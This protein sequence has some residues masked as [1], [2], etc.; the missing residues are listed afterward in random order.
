MCSFLHVAWFSPDRIEKD[1]LWEAIS[2]ASKYASGNLL[3]IGCGKKPYYKI[4]K[5]KVSSYIGLD[6]KDGDVTGSA[7]EL[8]FPDNYF[9]T[10]FSSQV[11]EHVE[12]P[13]LMMRESMRV[14]KKGGYL[15]LTAP[16]FWCLH[17]EP[18]D[19]FR[20]TK[21]GLLKLV[22]QANLTI[23]YIKER[24]CWPSTLGQ[25]ISLFLESTVNRTVLRFPKKILQ[26]VCQYILWHF[27]K[28]KRLSK[29]KQAPL[30][31]IMVAKKPK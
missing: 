19:F 24:G 22:E 18:R 31:Y 9:D 20:F 11:I 26:V 17:E 10:V 5:K 14:L 7:L 23:I 25:M 27:S 2:D 4:F 12:D 8:P 13:F 28:I 21:Y 6:L 30:G 15:I 29:N 3:D 16:L 1:T